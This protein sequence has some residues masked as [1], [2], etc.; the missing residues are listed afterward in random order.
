MKGTEGTVTSVSHTPPIT[1]IARTPARKRPMP[2]TP[3]TVTTS[4]T[5]HGDRNSDWI[6]ETPKRKPPVKQEIRDVSK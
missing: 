4:Q 6:M 3:V 5:S 2:P 1:S